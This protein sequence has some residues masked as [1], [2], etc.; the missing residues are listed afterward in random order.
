MLSHYAECS[1]K[2]FSPRYRARSD[3][4]HKPG[5]LWLSDDSDYGWY[6]LVS[7]Q[8]R[9]GSS[10][11]ADGNIRWRYRYDF[12]IDPAQI[13]RVL[14]LKTADDLRRF[15][16]DYQEP[17]PRECV[18]NGQPGFGLHIEWH[19]V[20]SDYKGILITPYQRQLS[21]RNGKPESHWYRFDCASGCFWD[22]TCLRLQRGPLQRPRRRLPPLDDDAADERLYE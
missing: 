4:E 12:T 16:A 21:H 15:T 3:N 10:D 13:G 11:W 22:I 19:R 2:V 18:V 9:S 8:M 1:N 17:S 14:L 6:D 7:D 20:K 5:G